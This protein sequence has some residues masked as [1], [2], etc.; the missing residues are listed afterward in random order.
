[1]NFGT[2]SM[3][4]LRHQ[5]RFDASEVRAKRGLRSTTTSSGVTAYNV[6]AVSG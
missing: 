6:A 1:M 3:A 5:K 4:H 2:R